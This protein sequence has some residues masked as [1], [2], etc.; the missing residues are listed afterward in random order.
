MAVVVNPGLDRSDFLSHVGEDVQHQGG[1]KTAVGGNQLMWSCHWNPRKASRIKLKKQMTDPRQK[2][3]D[4]ERRSSCRTLLTDW[5]GSCSANGSEH[6]R[7]RRSS[8]TEYFAYHGS[9]GASRYH[10]A[11]RSDHT[12]L[13]RSG[14]SAAKPATAA[15]RDPPTARGESPRLALPDKFDGSAD[16][17]R[18]FL[19]QCEVFFAH[20]P[21]MY[22][23][24][25]TQCAFVMSLLTNRALEWASAVWDADPQIRSSFSHFTGLI[26]EVFE[27]PAGGKD[28][29]VQLM[30]LHQGTD[31]AAD[32]AITF[33]TLAAQSGWNDASLWAVF[34]AGLNPDLQTELACRTEATTLS[35]FVATAIRLD[36][37]RRQHQAGTSRAGPVRHRSQTDYPSFREETPEPMQLGRSRLTSFAHPQQGRMRLCYHC[38]ASGHQSSRCPEREAPAKVGGGS[39]F[40]SLLVPVSLSVSDHW[41]SVSALIDSGAAVNLINGAL[42]ERLGI[43]TFPCVPSLR[44]TAIDSQPIGEGYLK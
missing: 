36:N 25:E 32:Y 20:Q 10:R 5:E 40:F 9:S 17:C 18:G 21:G 27:Y 35:Q 28:I 13:S 11:A 6:F 30:E 15:P 16:R 7:L 8:V 44:I 34:R 39:Q 33:R 14:G 29:S 24:E 26:R 12:L 31:T 42:V 19:R 3:R 22:S 2:S 4:A 23:N 41:I 43:P 1:V 38:G 37:L